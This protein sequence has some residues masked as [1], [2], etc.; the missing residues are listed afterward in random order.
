[1][2]HQAEID[3]QRI[4]AQA[5]QRC[6]EEILKAKREMEER[7]RKVQHGSHDLLQVYIHYVVAMFSVYS[8]T[9]LNI[10]QACLK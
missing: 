6:K 4:M 2:K 5:D 8:L 3:R 1:M 9:A 10:R 7:M